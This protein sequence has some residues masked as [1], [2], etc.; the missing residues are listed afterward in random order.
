MHRD[1]YKDHSGAHH[2]LDYFKPG[3]YKWQCPKDLTRYLKKMFLNI[4]FLILYKHKSYANWMHVISFFC[5][6]FLV[7]KIAF[8]LRPSELKLLCFNKML[9][10]LYI[11]DFFVFFS[12][13]IHLFC[14]PNFALSCSGYLKDNFEKLTLANS[15]NTN[16]VCWKNIS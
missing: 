11:L 7:R 6:R 15:Q 8:A 5:E 14:L 9:T 13:I 10:S 16:R 2:P 1:Q 3:E 12:L 4:I